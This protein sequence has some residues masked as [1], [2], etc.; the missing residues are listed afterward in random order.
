MRAAM[1][2]SHTSGGSVLIGCRAMRPPSSM[3]A[4]VPAGCGA[5]FVVRIYAGAESVAASGGEPPAVPCGRQ[6]GQS[7]PSISRGSPLRAARA[8]LPPAGSVSPATAEISPVNQQGGG[9]RTMCVSSACLASDAFAGA[10]QGAAART[11][12][13]VCRASRLGRAWRQSGSRGRPCEAEQIAQVRACRL[14]A[15]HLRRQAGNSFGTAVHD[16]AAGMTPSQKKKS[17]AAGQCN[18][19]AG[20]ACMCPA[21]GKSRT[22]CEAQKSGGRKGPA[23]QRRASRSRAAGSARC[24]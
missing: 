12:R 22:V 18:Y 15:L 24:A 16:R 19:S 5:T 20:P 8:A 13:S 23:A 2:S 4:Y 9:T 3:P 14:A 21:A 6:A 7:R 1:N 11:W 10:L 17:A